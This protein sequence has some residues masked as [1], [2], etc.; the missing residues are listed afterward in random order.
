VLRRALLPL[1]VWHAQTRAEWKERR[2][3]LQTLKQ[4]RELPRMIGFSGSLR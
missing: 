2:S 4:D 1:A 3:R